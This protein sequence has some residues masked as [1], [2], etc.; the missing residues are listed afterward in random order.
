MRVDL[1]SEPK[2]DANGHLTTDTGVEF[3]R[4]LNVQI[5]DVAAVTQ[6]ELLARL[7]E[8][9]GTLF[10]DFQR[11]QE[12]LLTKSVEG[13]TDDGLDL[14]FQQLCAYVNANSTLY[15]EAEQARSSAAGCGSGSGVVPVL[16]S[17]PSRLSRLLSHASCLACVGL[18]RRCGTTSRLTTTLWLRSRTTKT[19]AGRAAAAARGRRGHDRV[20]VDIGAHQHALRPRACSPGVPASPVQR[21][22][23]RDS[24]RL[25][26]SRRRACDL[27]PCACLCL[28]SPQVTLD[29]DVAHRGQALSGAYAG[30]L[31]TAKKAIVKINEVIFAG[32]GFKKNFDQLFCHE[33]WCGGGG[34]AV[35]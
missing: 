5:D 29:A 8:S 32:S 21:G 13:M 23:R 35:V 28:G 19:T 17:A 10:S 25:V 15:D 18:P 11:I 27:P 12:G 3:M 1:E 22:P 31:A 4:L 14:R 24:S 16:L 33:D 34:G 20:R 7:V 30:F 2:E 26:S 6:G 9:F